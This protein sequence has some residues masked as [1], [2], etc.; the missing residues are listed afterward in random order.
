[1]QATIN[2]NKIMKNKTLFLVSF[3]FI[4]N[5]CIQNKT[6]EK[7][8]HIEISP[9]DKSQTITIITKGDKRYFINGKHST[10]PNDNYL[11][12]DLS[13]VAPLGDGFS[14][15]WNDSNGYRWKIAST[16]AKIIENKLDT[17]KYHY[18]Q[19]IRKDDPPV[20]IGY[21]E[22][23]CGNLLIRENREPWGDLVVKY[24]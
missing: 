14:I 6:H 17:S 18:Y 13:K 23:N 22:K 15:C 20:S 16:Y 8:R 9:M 24:K 2:L 1:M 21:K 12:L 10:I 11:L 3:I 19:P 7:W 4:L 5:S